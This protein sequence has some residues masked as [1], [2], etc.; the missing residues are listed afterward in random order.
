M[1]FITHSLAVEEFLGSQTTLLVLARIITKLALI[2]HDTVSLLGSPLHT[3]RRSDW[4]YDVVYI[5]RR[6]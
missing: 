5:T 3:W 1:F 4:Y 2:G 6:Q